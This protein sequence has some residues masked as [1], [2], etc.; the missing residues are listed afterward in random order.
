MP[1]P[2]TRLIIPLLKGLTGL[3]CR[4][5]DAEL[6]KVPP[7]GP[8]IL[9]A[10]HIGL[11]EIP[12]LYTHLQPR[13]FTGFVAAYRWEKGWSR[14]LLD[15]CDAIPLRRGEVD[16]NAMRQAL[17]W[18]ASGGILAIAPEGTRSHDGH[19]RS[20][21]AGIILLAEQSGAPIIPLA[22]YGS[23]NFEANIRRLKR[24]DFI[25][26]VG[27]LIELKTLQQGIPGGMTRREL[28][29]QLTDEIMHRIAT[30]MPEKYRGNYAD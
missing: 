20:A 8:L 28:R 5:E 15:Q 11:L 25:I 18:L 4:I 2:S 17:D 16:L 12:I 26:R 24:T 23:E 14:W 10:N 19:L 6:A 3:L 22:F 27:E 21:H 7:R 30:M 29:Q 1:T 13:P 9:A